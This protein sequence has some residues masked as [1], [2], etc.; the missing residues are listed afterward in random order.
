[1]GFLLPTLTIVVGE[2][3]K[4]ESEGQLRH[5]KPLLLALLDNIAGR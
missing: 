5:C 3:T 2:L 4:I 1:M